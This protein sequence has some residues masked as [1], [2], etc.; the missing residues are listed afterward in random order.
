MK[1]INSPEHKVPQLIQQ[2]TCNLNGA[3]TITET[4]FIIYVPKETAPGAN[5]FTGDFAQGLQK[6]NT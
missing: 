4:E 3:V 5:Y 6:I 2:E 1:W